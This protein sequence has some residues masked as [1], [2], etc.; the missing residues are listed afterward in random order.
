MLYGDNYIFGGAN[1]YKKANMKMGV[2]PIQVYGTFKVGEQV[3]VRG[4]NFTPFS[5]VN[6]DGK[7]ISTSFYSPEILGQYARE[8]RLPAGSASERMHKF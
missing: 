7:I 4:K 3:Y 6:I 5:K 8:H 2:K 1:P